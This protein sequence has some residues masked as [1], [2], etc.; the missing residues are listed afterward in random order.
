MLDIKNL[1][2]KYKGSNK[3]I[4]KNIDFCVENGEVLVVLGKN[5]VGKTTLLKCILSLLKKEEGMV[6]FDGIDIGKLNNLDRAKYLAYVSQD[7][8]NSHLNVY[9]TIM[10]GRLPYQKMFSSKE[11]YRIV[12]EIIE[13][14][15]LNDFA[16]RDIQTLSSGERQKV[17]IARAL[18][19]SSKI[20]VFDEPTASLDIKNYISITNTIKEITHGNGII[21]IIAMH[22]INLAKTVGDK[23]LLLNDENYIFGSKEILT[24]ANLCKIY[25]I[26]KEELM[27][28]LGGFVNE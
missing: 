11:D 6:L 2:F 7:K 25:G 23:F 26:S 22:D 14:L 8:I 27:V 12:D 5:G 1:S 10:L 18:A 17:M 21:S 15:D 28:A 4:L 3:N 16:L 19:Q 24:I 9:D 13:K 20:I